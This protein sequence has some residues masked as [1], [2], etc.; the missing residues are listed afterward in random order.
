VSSSALHD[1]GHD[2]ARRRAAGGTGHAATRSPAAVL[3]AL[4]VIAAALRFGTL[5]V[6]SIW[7]DESATLLLLHRGF[8]GMLSHLA[9]SE[10]SPPLYYVLVW[11]WTKIFGAG[12]LGVRS[13]SALV[14]TLTVPALYLAGRAVSPRVGLWAAALA[15]FSPAMFYYS[16]E[17][18]CYALL[19][20]FSAAAL[21]VWQRALREPSAR[22]LALWALLSALALLSHYFAVFLFIPEA[23]MLARR[24]GL[25]RTLLPA[26]AVAAVGAALLPLAISQHTEA[27]KT[28]WI[29]S[30]SLPARIA[31]TAKDFLVGLYGPLEILTA[32]ACLALALAALAMLWQRGRPNERLAARE[33]TIVA[34]VALALPLLAAASRVIDVFDGRNVI[35]AW[36][37]AAVVL[38]IALGGARVGRAGTL[39][40][41]GF[42]AIALA[43]IVATDLTPGYQRD[44]WRGA[45][46]ALAG[47][48]AAGRLIVTEANGSFPLGIYLHGGPLTRVG[49]RT[50]ARVVDVVLLRERRSARSPLA[51][52]PATRLLPGF[53]LAGVRSSDTYAVSSFVAAR[54]TAVTLKAI[55]KLL[56]AQAEVTAQLR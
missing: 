27:R 14:G 13:F 25:R 49:A 35:E 29:E 20:L 7:L 48:P 36:V 8:S 40:G 28:E 39:L 30:T 45:A 46:G 4:T 17:A 6:Q 23:A 47:P 16:Q 5:D 22:R 55:H 37:P 38:A 51:P 3:L 26:G 2:A 1:V 11:G 15:T 32:L 53:R 18:R 9:A 24:A 34:G 21:V 56:G 31:Q 10:S 54:P 52:R 44:D 12:P 50:S 42:C 19:I 43:V 33:L 41:V